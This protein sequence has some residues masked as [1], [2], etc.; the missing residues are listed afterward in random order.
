MPLHFPSE[1]QEAK[2][3][4]IRR[5][6]EERAAE[7]HAQS[8]QLPYVN[9]QTVPIDAE[10]I[11]MV[12]EPE[13]RRGRLAIVQRTGFA[14]RIA[15]EDPK[16]GEAKKTLAQL[17][18]DG[19]ESHLF[20]ASRASLEKAWK[21][22]RDVRPKPKA[23]TGR[24]AISQ[25]RIEALQKTLTSFAALRGEIE[26]V[27]PAEATDALEV[28]LAGTL[29]LDASDVHIEPAAGAGK[30]RLRLDGVL[31][32]IT[33]I[34]TGENKELTERIKLLSGLKL[35]ITESP[36]D[37]RF[38]IAAAG[39]EI[40]IRTSTLP[41]EYG[42]N[43][44]LR[45]LNPNRVALELSSLGLRPD[46][47]NL[48]EAELKEPNGMILTT[49]PTGSGKTTTLYACLKRIASPE[50]KVITIEDPI[51]YHL[52][53]LE[54]TQIDPANKYDFADALRAVVRQDPDVILVGEIRDL[55]TAE[56]ALHASLTGHLV[57]STLH[58]NDAA[59]TVPRL[60]DL[61]AKPPI[62]APAIN[63]AMAQRLVR[64]LCEKCKE[65]YPPDKKFEHELFEMIE[66]LPEAVAQPHLKK[67]LA[68]YRAKGCAACHNTGYKGRIAVYEMFRFDEEIEKIILSQPTETSLQ[69]A[70]LK[71]GMVTL[72]D[73]GLLRVLEGITTIEEMERVVG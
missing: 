24:V 28:L 48:L 10:A 46:L 71:Q 59:G 30:I 14:L 54:Q 1:K 27:L 40:E 9:L 33:E 35:N 5:G 15:L 26:R 4:A 43:V 62:I 6:E 70:A 21:I 73:D 22:Y 16:D 58:T 2:L 31:E 18:G 69:H 42:E 49:G 13:A 65:S 3:K 63:L 47:L 17:A 44:V 38:S 34:P 55:E 37:G 57:F 36:Q 20:V 50:I 53:G 61:G 25:T 19:F 45:V 72:R 52:A 60:I 39:V 7:R 23:I 56:A 12:P 66:G 32:D 68:L 41:G 51:E 11:V 64:R 29:A 8:L 67:P